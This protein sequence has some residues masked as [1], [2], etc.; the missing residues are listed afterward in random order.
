[1]QA[2]GLKVNVAKTKVTTG[3]EGLVQL[4]NVPI[5]TGCV[6]EVQGTILLVYTKICR[7]SVLRRCIGVM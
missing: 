2:E 5:L 4:R 7:T 6:A 1:M 3:G